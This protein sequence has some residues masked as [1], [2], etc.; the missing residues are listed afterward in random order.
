MQIEFYDII[1]RF[2]VTCATLKNR[3]LVLFEDF[4]LMLMKDTLHKNEVFH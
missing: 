4:V 2:S 3:N 1:F